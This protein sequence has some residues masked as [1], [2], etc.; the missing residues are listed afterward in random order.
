[1]YLDFRFLSDVLDLNDL[2]GYI[3]L[4]VSSQYREKKSTGKLF[5]IVLDDLKITRYNHSI[6]NLHNM[7]ELMLQEVKLM[8]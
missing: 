8:H 7:Q 5:E 6:Q 4:Y 2:S 1:M 3:K